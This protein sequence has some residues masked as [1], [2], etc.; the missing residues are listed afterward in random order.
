MGEG[1]GALPYEVK[2][3]TGD[4]SAKAQRIQSEAAEIENRLAHLT[5]AIGDL[6]STWSGTA[7][8][9]F[10]ELYREWDR[11]AR[12]MKDALENIGRSLNKAGTDYDA[13]EQQLTTQFGK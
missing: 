8:S 12:Q 13:L 2:V 10:Q 5:T 1:A 11:T 9:A 6:A 7:A 3:S 4:V